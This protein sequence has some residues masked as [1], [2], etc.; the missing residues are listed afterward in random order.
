MKQTLFPLRAVRAARSQRTVLSMVACACALLL[1]SGV[2]HSHGN[3]DPLLY[4]VSFDEL[5]WRGGSGDDEL[6]W[7]G[8]AWVGKYEHR[9][10][11]KTRGERTSDTTEEFEL[12]LLY[13]QAI[14]PFWDLQ[15]GWRG[16]FQPADERSWFA[17]GFEGLAP[18]FIESELT[19]FAGGSGRTAA[20]ARFAYDLLFTQRLILEPELE[21]DWYGKDD[22]ANRI[23]SGIASLEAGLRLRYE[24]RRE[25][26]PYIGFN[27]TRLYG[28]TKRYARADGEDSSDLRVLAGLRFWF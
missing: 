16:D 20:R 19:A 3:D 18:G 23:G 11:L 13:N 14:A 22:P 4:M 9:L 28:D 10:L 26:A 24:L 15:Y 12:Q 5:E 21:L 6:A 17:L 25:F 8:E 7:R 27:W 1:T 2:S